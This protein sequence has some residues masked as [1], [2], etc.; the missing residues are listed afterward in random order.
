MENISKK[1]ATALLDIGAVKVRINPPF[2]WVSGIKSPVYCDNRMMIS[3][4]A[5]RETV[6]QAF[7]EIL[8][9]KIA[10]GEMKEPDYIGG[11]ATA[12]IPWAA[13]LAYEL[14]K[15]MI[16]IRPEP[17]AHGAGKQI[18]GDLKEGSSVLIVEDLISTGGSSVKV[19]E[20]VRKE[21][22]C[23]VTDIFAI[24][25]WEMPKAVAAFKEGNV[26]LT[27]LTGF[28]DLIGFAAER[29][30]I[31]ADKVEII[32]KFKENPAVWGDGL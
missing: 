31:P 24:V 19:A 17:K 26:N 3:H 4:V 16:Y 7:K 18:E 25:S 20:V 12:A 30:D 29:G 32:N 22:K 6:V 11:T 21:G 23:E 5:G 27:N 15:P 9:D 8:A 13:F 14:K 28:T 10:K 1:V 2:T